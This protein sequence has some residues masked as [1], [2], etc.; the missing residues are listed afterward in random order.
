MK[1]RLETWTSSENR[2]ER[3]FFIDEFKPTAYQQSPYVFGFNPQVLN[4]EQV[5]KILAIINAELPAEFL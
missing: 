4:Q 5:E 3:H 1:L 2:E